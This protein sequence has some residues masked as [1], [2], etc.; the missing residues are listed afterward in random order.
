MTEDETEQEILKKAEQYAKEHGWV[1]NPDKKKLA[2]VVKG[3]AR[4]KKKFG[5]QIPLGPFL[6]LGA[7]VVLFWGDALWAWYLSFL[8]L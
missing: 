8:G 6:A 4:G 3:L 7:L 5:E 1:L 2:D